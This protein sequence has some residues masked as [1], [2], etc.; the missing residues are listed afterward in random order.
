MVLSIIF[1][2]DK[3]KMLLHLSIFY[4]YQQIFF[5]TVSNIDK[6]NK[7]LCL[8]SRNMIDKTMCEDLWRNISDFYVNLRVEVRKHPQVIFILDKNNERPDWK[9]SH[10]VLSI[11]FL[12][13]KHKILLHLSIFYEFQ[14]FFQHVSV[15]RYSRNFNS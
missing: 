14:Q 15:S 9:S 10:M 2:E 4:E 13:D 12:E 1:L 7:I 3:H 11:I 8:S 5:N 6:C